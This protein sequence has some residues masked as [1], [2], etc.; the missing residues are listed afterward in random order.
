MKLLFP[1]P[2]RV[3]AAIALVC[4]LLPASAQATKSVIAAQG[5]LS[6]AAGLP[7]ADGT[8]PLTL[9]L[10]SDAVG[11]IPVF[12]EVF[13][14]VPVA[15][16]MFGVQLGASAFTPLD[17]ALFVG[18]TA[19][20]VGVTVA[21]DPELARVALRAVPYAV[22]AIS[23]NSALTAAGLSCTGCVK[24]GEIAAG[25]VTSDK[26]AGGAVGVAQLT[27]TFVKDMGLALT[28]NFADVAFSGKY[29]DLANSPDL[30]QYTTTKGL[31]PVA[32]SGK[33]ADLS[34]G[35]DLTPYAK[36]VDLAPYAP[37]AKA[38]TF[39]KTQ[40]FGA[41]VITAAAADPAACDGTTIGLL[42]FNT[43]KFTLRVCDGKIYRDIS[44][45]GEPGSETNPGTSCKDIKTKK[46]ALADGVYWIAPGVV[47]K[48]QAY[49]DMTTDGGGWTLCLSNIERGKGTALSDT[50]E[51][52][53]TVWDKGVRN[54]TRGN[55]GSGNAWGNFCK[56]M[57]PEATQIYSTIYAENN[58]QNTGDICTLD[59]NWFNAGSGYK[60]LACANN[61]VMAAIPKNNYNNQGCVGCIFWSDESAPNA[62]GANWGH[63]YYGTHVMV[64]LKGQSAYGAGGIHWGNVNPGMAD[65][66]GGDVHCGSK[67][68]WCYEAYWG[69]NT[70]LKSMQF[71]VR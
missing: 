27:A 3:L 7:V 38:N 26:I 67:G 60:K 35:P 50:N 59:A 39:P 15:S 13:V 69:G 71:Y 43:V 8:Y 46:P 37:L 17:D 65:A 58:G 45:I 12:Q 53:T 10:Y 19:N 6:N 62:Q 41:G 23:A 47:P 20:Y 30:T 2:L 24:S 33:Y 5:R 54:F 42:Y 16:G 68:G 55:K 32:L 57:Q 51:W 18:N 44:V 64:Q 36:T 11:G 70:W 63:N 48:F 40:T 22:S 52:W 28:K 31:A 61:T 14:A 56:Q 21:G 49:C 9:A 66:N 29:A 34:G 25:A 4:T 1:L